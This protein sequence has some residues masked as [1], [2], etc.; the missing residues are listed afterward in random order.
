MYQN[1]LKHTQKSSGEDFYS[2]YFIFMK[3]RKEDIGD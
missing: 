2:E 1:I 3:E